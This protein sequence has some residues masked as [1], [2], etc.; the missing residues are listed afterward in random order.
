ML[1]IITAV[2]LSLSLSVPADMHHTRIHYITGTMT[3]HL[4][5]YYNLVKALRYAT[6][7]KTINVLVTNSPGGRISTYHYLHYKMKYSKGKVMVYTQGTVASAAAMISFSGD[8]MVVRHNTIFVF[9]AVRYYSNGKVIIPT[10]DNINTARKRRMFALT[11]MLFNRI[12]R[13]NFTK[14]Q[15]RGIMY[16]MDVYI[17]GKKFCK[18]AVK[19]KII[20]KK[21]YC[22]IK[23]LKRR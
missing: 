10:P 5:K 14:R 7:G 11:K 23:G 19:Y 16:G 2:L 12:G 6:K 4:G 18:Q 21:T 3:S 20:Q 17:G 22:V 8:Y 1:S 13:H 15:W 9:H